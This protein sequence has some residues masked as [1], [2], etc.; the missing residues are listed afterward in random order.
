ML[1][2]RRKEGMDEAAQG[3]DKHI[4]GEAERMSHMLEI[5]FVYA[6]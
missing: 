6:F 4:H 3:T 5:A 2:K 1:K